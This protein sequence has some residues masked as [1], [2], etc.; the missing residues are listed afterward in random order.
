MLT[1]KSVFWKAVVEELLWFISGSTNSKQLSEKGVRI[2]DANS[3]RE[4]LD[5]YGFT[6]REEG[7][8]GP[9]YGF[10]W[11]HCGAEYTNMHADY[12]GKGKINKIIC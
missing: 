4:Y 6:E 5:S 11:R 7:D 2:W 9:I 8:L 3:S 1:T 10:Q 12:T